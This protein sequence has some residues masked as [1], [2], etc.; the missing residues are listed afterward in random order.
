MKAIFTRTYGPHRVQATDGDGNTVRIDRDGAL[1]FEA[2]HDAAAQALCAK[3]DWAGTLVKG[4]VLRAGANV[5]R[6]YVWSH[7][8]LVTTLTIE[9]TR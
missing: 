3:C 2:Q 5:G 9:R 4:Y 6:V 1:G 7:S 8:D